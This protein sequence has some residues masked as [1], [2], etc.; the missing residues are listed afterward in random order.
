MPRDYKAEY[1][2]Y[3]SK[4]EQIANRSARN[5]ARRAMAKKVGKAA[6]A[7]K[8]VGHAKPLDRGGSNAAS[9]LKV[10]SVQKNRGWRRGRSGYNP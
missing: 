4:P 6:L 1:A 9:N 2:K 5:Q 3:H 8:D 7:G 10:Q